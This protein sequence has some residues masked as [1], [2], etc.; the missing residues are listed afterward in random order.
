MR[1]SLER[2]VDR[3]CRLILYNA[4]TINPQM[5]KPKTFDNMY[6]IPNCLWQLEIAKTT[7]QGSRLFQLFDVELGCLGHRH[8]APHVGQGYEWSCARQ[9]DK[10]PRLNIDQK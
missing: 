8:L 5:P 6:G 10:S 4:E 7:E 9:R 3:F 1:H 2:S